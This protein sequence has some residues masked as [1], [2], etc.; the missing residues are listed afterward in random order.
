[1]TGATL[2]ERVLVPVADAEDA[3]TTVRVL[4][5]YHPDRVV[6]IHV[7]EK[8]GGALDKASVEQR[9]ERAK[10]I[11]AAVEEGFEGMDTD[12]GTEIRYGTDVANAIVEAAGDHDASAIVFSPREGSRWVR[13]LTGDVALSLV[14]ESDRPVVV[15][16]EESAETVADGNGIIEGEGARS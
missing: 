3:H 12:I 9:Q 7:I 8:A 16:P 15:L 10:E 6:A 13:L 5:A 1:M 11:F 2:T 4:R 14:T